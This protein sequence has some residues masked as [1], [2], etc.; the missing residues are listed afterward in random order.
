METIALNTAV[1]NTS[2]AWALLSPESPHLVERVSFRF[3]HMFGMMDGDIVGNSLQKVKPWWSNST[4]LRSVLLTASTGHRAADMIM[5]CTASGSEFECQLTCVPVMSDGSGRVEH[6]WARFQLPRT[7]HCSSL[8]I[9]GMPSACLRAMPQDLDSTILPGNSLPSAA[10]CAVIRPT[11][12]EGRGSPSRLA[13]WLEDLVAE[14]ERRGPWT[15]TTSAACDTGMR[16]RTSALP[17][18]LAPAR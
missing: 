10:N 18:P 4:R 17:L 6:L 9:Y 11:V 13:P 7:E 16:G 8:S 3:K 2:C 1:S 5:G 12:L 15:M 14:R